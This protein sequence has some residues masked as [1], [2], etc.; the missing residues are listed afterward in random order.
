MIAHGCGVVPGSAQALLGLAVVDDLLDDVAETIG[1]FRVFLVRHHSAPI[2]FNH[3]AIRGASAW[4]SS[5]IL[6]IMVAM[7]SCG[8]FS[9]ILLARNR[10]GGPKA[11]APRGS[12]DRAA[13]PGPSYHLVALRTFRT[14]C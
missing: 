14:P 9:S 4:T 3:A 8:V 11:T 5:R 6:G 1:V 12:Q 13:G 2:R 7:I 10:I